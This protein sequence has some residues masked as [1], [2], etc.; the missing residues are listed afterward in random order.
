M[1]HKIPERSKRD[2]LISF[3]AS[4]KLSVNTGSFN[5]IKIKGGLEQFE[6]TKKP[7]VS[8]CTLY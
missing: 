8:K 5:F 7:D 6:D 3:S 1:K 2:N 4:N